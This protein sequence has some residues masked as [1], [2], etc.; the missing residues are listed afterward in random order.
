MKAPDGQCFIRE[1]RRSSKEGKKP[2][3]NYL[4]VNKE[5]AQGKLEECIGVALLF[6]RVCLWGFISGIENK[7]TT[8]NNPAILFN[9]FYCMITCFKILEKWLDEFSEKKF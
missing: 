6:P 8:V 5:L 4:H 2:G 3:L 7:V 9:S 1:E